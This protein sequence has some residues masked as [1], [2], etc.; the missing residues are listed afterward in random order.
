MLLI[1]L[2]DYNRVIVV[3]M[4]NSDKSG[5]IWK[6]SQKLLVLELVGSQTPRSQGQNLYDP[7]GWWIGGQRKSQQDT[8]VYNRV[9]NRAGKTLTNIQ[10]KKQ[11]CTCDHVHPKNDRLDHSIKNYIFKF[12]IC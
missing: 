1:L 9:E 8:L 3:V 10:V 7:N 12:K 6:F 5:Q 2:I 4:V 11:L